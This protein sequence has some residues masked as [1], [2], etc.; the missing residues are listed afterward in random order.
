M[1]AR[2]R[3]A[4][5]GPLTTLRCADCGGPLTGLDVGAHAHEGDLFWGHESPRPAGAAVVAACGRCG[6]AWADAEELGRAGS[7][8]ALRAMLARVA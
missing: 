7:R 8:E 3:L 2:L 6:G 5:R 4:S 1:L